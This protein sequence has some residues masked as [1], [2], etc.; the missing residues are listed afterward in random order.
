MIGPFWVANISL[1]AVN[2][3]VVVG[4]LYVYANNFGQLRS[5]L[6]LGLIVFSGVL[7]VQ[8]IAAAL[9]YWQLAQTYTAVVAK[10]LL[11]MTLLETIALLFLSWT[12]WR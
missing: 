7:M 9:I 8:N 12:T 6:G 11:L 10:P 3:A 2:A 1:A 4:L 5:K